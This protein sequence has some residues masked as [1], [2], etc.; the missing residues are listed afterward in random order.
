MTM[1]KSRQRSVTVQRK[2]LSDAGAYSTGKHVR[3]VPLHP[4]KASVPIS[5][6]AGGRGKATS[7]DAF[8][9]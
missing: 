5:A 3:V 1:A 4:P 6:L 2:A 8:A 9:A 7:G